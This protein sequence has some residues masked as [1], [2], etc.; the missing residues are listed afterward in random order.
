MVVRCCWLFLL[1]SS[2]HVSG[3]Y[4]KWARKV[5]RSIYCALGEANSTATDAI[6]NIRTVRG[7]ST[8]TWG[9]SETEKTIIR[10]EFQIYDDFWWFLMLCDDF[11]RFVT[12]C[13]DLWWFLTI[14]DDLW[15]YC[16]YYTNINWRITWTVLNCSLHFCREL[17]KIKPWNRLVTAQRF[18]IKAERFPHESDYKPGRHTGDVIMQDLRK[19]IL[20]V[21]TFVYNYWKLLVQDQDALKL[22]LWVAMFGNVWPPRSSLKPI[23]MPTAS[24]LHWATVWRTLTW[25]QPWLH[26][27]RTWTWVRRR[28]FYGMV[29]SWSVTQRARLWVL[30]PWSLSNCTGKL[31]FAKLNFV[32]LLPFFTGSFR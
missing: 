2:F 23:S 4:A 9:R 6:G 24:T 19:F 14:C 5:T 7:F 18:P 29:D 10:L 17:W 31:P 13:D 3:S 15:I 12:I 27:P 28:W 26:F 32:F 20:K 8:D 21:R 25:V 16:L 1:P 22:Y 11:W 30:A